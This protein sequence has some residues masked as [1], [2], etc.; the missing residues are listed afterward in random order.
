[1]KFPK[2]R[3]ITDLHMPTGSRDIEAQSKKHGHRHFLD[4]KPHFHLNEDQYDV[5]VALQKTMEN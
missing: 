3:A 1:M 4:F 2:E 5:T